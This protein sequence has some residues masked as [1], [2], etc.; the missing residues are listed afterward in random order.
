[1]EKRVKRLGVLLGAGAIL[2]G[3]ALTFQNKLEA[4]TTDLIGEYLMDIAPEVELVS[5]GINNS[6]ESR[7]VSTEN[8]FNLDDE[9]R[10]NKVSLNKY[11]TWVDE[12]LEYSKTE[13]KPVIIIDKAAETLQLYKNGE[14]VEEFKIELGKNP[15]D[16]KFL[17]GDNMT[18][19]GKYS[20]NWVRGLGNTSF[21]RAYMLN[22]P[23][24]EDK[25]ELSKL[26]WEGKVK[27]FTSAGSHIEIHGGGAKD[28]EKKR[29]W[30]NGCMAL[31]NTDI[32]KLF[33]DHGLEQGTKVTIVRYGTKSNYL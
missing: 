31:S 13:Q 30:T 16:D 32:D 20:I 29:N 11:Q 24:E 27:P 8:P 18:P 2:V 26:K 22:Y 1:M 10:Y 23:N 17:E 19:E 4:I 12:T 3:S 21:H 5:K 33:E 28:S 6:L 25:K 14:L 15:I 7:L 9:F